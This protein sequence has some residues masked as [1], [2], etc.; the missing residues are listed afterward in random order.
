MMIASCY[1]L[2]ATRLECCDDGRSGLSFGEH[3]W[4]FLLVAACLNW[5]FGIL[6]VLGLRITRPWPGL[7]VD[8]FLHH[9]VFVCSGPVA[10][11]MVV[12]FG[13]DVGDSA[14]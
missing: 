3:L 4:Q 2:L 14:M 5:A 1:Q 9:L 6:F 12:L 11:L 13:G 8:T 7:I 10:A